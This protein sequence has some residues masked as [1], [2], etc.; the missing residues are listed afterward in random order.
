MHGHKNHTKRKFEHEKKAN[1]RKKKRDVCS[2]CCMV[3]QWNG[4]DMCVK[5][6][7]NGRLLTIASFSLTSEIRLNEQYSNEMN[8][9]TNKRIAEKTNTTTTMIAIEERKYWM[10]E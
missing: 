8:L 6:Y 5:R 7:G 10:I 4:P 2:C 3:I 1:M 9:W